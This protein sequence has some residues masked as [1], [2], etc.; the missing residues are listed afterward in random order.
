MK[1]KSDFVTNSSSSSF[2]VV[3]PNRIR[4]IR[5]VEK[6]IPYKYASTV[7]NDA[8]SQKPRL[9]RQKNLLNWV[10]NEIS[11][12]YVIGSDD[13]DYHEEFCEREGID[14]STYNNRLWSQIIYDEYKLMRV[15]KI[16]KIALEFLKDLSGDHYVYKFTYADDSGEYFAEMEHGDIFRKLPNLQI[17]KH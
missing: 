10:A 12:G 7:F 17:S 11:Y 15:S 4:T 13:Y 14:I 16:S 3:F 2:I 5:D 9:V 8:L 6:F 1:T